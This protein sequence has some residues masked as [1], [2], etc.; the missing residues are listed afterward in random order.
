MQYEPVPVSPVATQSVTDLVGHI[1]EFHNHH[2]RVA[3]T[4][5]DSNA[6]EDSGVSFME[7][8]NEFCRHYPNYGF[9]DNEQSST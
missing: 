9:I 3:A 1:E 4:H 8:Q 7:F 2:P 5:Q 6:L